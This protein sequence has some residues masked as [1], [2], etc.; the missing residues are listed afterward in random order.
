[1]RRRPRSIGLG[2]DQLEDPLHAGP[3]LLADGQHHGEH[4][5]RA[6]E[7]GEVGGEGDE[8]AEGDLPAGG[9]PAAERQHRDLAERGD[10]LEGRGVAGVQPDGAQPAGEELPADLAQLAGLLLLLAEALD[11]ADA[12]DG[13]VDDAGDGG[14]L[15]LG[16]PGG[17]EEPGAAAR[18]R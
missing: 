11:D 9:Q 16:V 17:G 13:A 18:W 1:M 7:L 15:A 2:V 12:G 4:P 14:G 8:G 3:G 5:D 6:D 10:G